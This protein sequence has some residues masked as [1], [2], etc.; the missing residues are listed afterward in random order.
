MKRSAILTLSVGT[1]AL[2]AQLWCAPARAQDAGGDAATEIVGKMQVAVGQLTKLDTGKPTQATQKQ[3]VDKLDELIAQLEKECENCRGSRVNPHPSK[4]AQDST[5]RN[6]P[7]GSGDLHAAHKE[8]KN[9]GELP[10]H[11]RDRILQSMTEGFPPHYQRILERYYKRLAQ[12]TPVADAAEP[13]ALGNGAAPADK[14]GPSGKSDPPGKAA[15]GNKTEPTGNPMPTGE[16]KP[17]A[18]APSP[19]EGGS[20]Q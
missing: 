12:E 4:P 18:S 2:G 20:K 3:I 7:G 15:Q 17:A 16:P 9:W 6:G 14:T 1:L 8:G 5:I 19:A 13:S 10:P 11:E